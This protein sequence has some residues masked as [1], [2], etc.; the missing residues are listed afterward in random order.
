MNGFKMDEDRRTEY[1]R[2]FYHELGHWFVAKQ[3]GFEPQFIELKSERPSTWVSS[4][5]CS[6]VL[7]CKC[8]GKDD[9]VDYLMKR[10]QVLLAGAVFEAFNTGLSVSD[11]IHNLH[12]KTAIDDNK[13]FMEL[14]M[15][16][17]N[18]KLGEVE[19]DVDS[20]CQK[21]NVN[22]S[23]ELYQEIL[24]HREYLAGLI[25]VSC[26]GEINDFIVSSVR[27]LDKHLKKDG[28]IGKV[29]I[30]ANELEEIYNATIKNSVLPKKIIPFED[31]VLRN[32]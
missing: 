9:V 4:G 8:E 5:F 18:L 12:N 28:W 1:L 3:V 26:K 7:Y 20:L 27:L 10:Q 19:G 31:G 2:V 6:T 21:L 17:L 29:T 15:I 13:K 23:D 14:A 22:G 30:Q 32:L 11:A 25:Y 24:R 16:S